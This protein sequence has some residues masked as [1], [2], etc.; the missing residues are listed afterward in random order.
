MNPRPKRTP[1]DDL[2][3][4]LKQAKEA[5]RARELNFQLIVDSI[6]AQVAVSPTGQVVTLNQPCLD[7][8]GKTLDELKGWASSDPVHPEDLPHVIEVLKHALETGETY[9]VESRH[10]RYDGVYCWF[11]LR[12]FPLKGTEG[13]IL[14]WCVLLT[15]TD[16]RKRGELLLRESEL[17]FKAIFDEAGAGLRWLISRA[18]FSLEKRRQHQRAVMKSRPLNPRTTSVVQLILLLP[19]LEWSGEAISPL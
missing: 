15:D 2:A 12:G 14:R 10:R 6:P 8:F 3:E 17:H 4:R 7:Y 19:C 18:R 1:G 11:H 13:A 16:D 9:E 5:L